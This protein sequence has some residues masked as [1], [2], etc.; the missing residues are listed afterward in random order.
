MLYLTG[1]LR[2]LPFSL[3]IDAQGRHLV[4]TRRLAIYTASAAEQIDKD[5]SPRW[6]VNA[7]ASSGGQ[8]SAA[9]PALPGVHDEIRAIV[10][11]ERYPVGILAGRAWMDG[12]FTRDAWRRVLDAPL[13]ERASVM[14][15]A[16]HFR[17]LPG[18]WNDSYLLLGNG[19][20]F[21]ISELAGAA[22]LNLRDVELVTLSAC[23]TE[24]T[25]QA[26]GVEVEGL[27]VLLQKKGARA[28]IGTLWQV[29]D[30]GAAPLMQAFYAA[31]GEQR[32]MSKAA[33]LQA[34]QLRL[35][36]GEV[37]SGTPGVDL[38]HPYYW[39]PFVLMGNWL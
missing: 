25:D 1:Q 38:R 6:N 7:F 11:N 37:K 19:D 15:L 4:Q 21:R 12:E 18:R 32:S 20:E 2:Y 13:G 27:G 31:R 9:L 23:A 35:L 8:P 30:A 28:V 3:L 17:L 10:R 26:E 34:A 39:A 33:A 16:T 36:S 29:S 14:H 5:P 24:L 22:S